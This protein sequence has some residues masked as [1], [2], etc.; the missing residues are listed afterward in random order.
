MLSD[1]LDMAKAV[2]TTKRQQ[3]PI[4][5]RSDACKQRYSRQV[6]CVKCGCED[7]NL[8]SFE[9]VDALIELRPCIERGDKDAV[10]HVWKT[11]RTQPWMLKDLCKSC[12][13]AMM[14]RTFDLA[15]ARSARA[16]LA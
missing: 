7:A 1:S 8:K 10:E 5:L 16:I 14:P 6:V 9:N 11:V 13:S 2:I 12:G 3:N 4:T 15:C